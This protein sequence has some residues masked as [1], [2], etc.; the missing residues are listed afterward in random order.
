MVFTTPQ[1]YLALG[2]ALLFAL[3]FFKKVWVTK[4]QGTI[5]IVALYFL[6]RW[7]WK[8]LLVS[9]LVYGLPSSAITRTRFIYCLC[10]P[11]RAV[12]IPNPT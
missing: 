5:F 11:L 7:D 10:E 4:P 12:E 8:G 3:V 1:I 2:G 9:L 6:L